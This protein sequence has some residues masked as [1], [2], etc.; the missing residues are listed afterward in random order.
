MKRYLAKEET[1]SHKT[2]TQQIQK[3]RGHREAGEISNAP[4][5]RHHLH[6]QGYSRDEDV[7]LSG[8]EKLVRSIECLAKVNLEEILIQRCQGLAELHLCCEHGP[9][10][11]NAPQYSQIVHR[12]SRG[13]I[14]LAVTA[15]GPRPALV[16][17]L[18]TRSRSCHYVLG[19]SQSYLIALFTSG[20]LPL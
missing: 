2:P 3:H 14:Y 6:I 20:L 5:L 4:G 19:K 10:V 1:R 11:R 13:T 18:Y 15:N 17:E 7:F 9:N 16:L 8:A 12:S